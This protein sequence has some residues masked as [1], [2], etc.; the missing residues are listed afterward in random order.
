MCSLHVSYQTISFG[1]NVKP[2]SVNKGLNWGLHMFSSSVRFAKVFDSEDIINLDSSDTNR[3]QIMSSVLTSCLKIFLTSGND[4]W[5]SSWQNSAF[6]LVNVDNV[7]SQRY[8]FL[9]KIFNKK[10]KSFKLAQNQE[11][12]TQN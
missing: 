8:F 7:W 4:V 10:Q 2:S 3:G 1:S 6:K 11:W 9:T 5:L 12:Y